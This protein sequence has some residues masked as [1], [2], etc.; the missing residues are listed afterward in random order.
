MKSKYQSILCLLLHISPW[1]K[2]IDDTS[3]KHQMSLLLMPSAVTHKSPKITF[4]FW[5]ISEQY[6]SS[7]AQEENATKWGFKQMP[8]WN[9]SVKVGL[10]LWHMFDL[11][12]WVN[13]NCGRLWE[14]KTQEMKLRHLLVQTAAFTL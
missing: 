11:I 14:R 12:I 5:Y 13:E 4:P 7:T 9:F 2:N 10:D 6:F 3:C 1:I 8:L